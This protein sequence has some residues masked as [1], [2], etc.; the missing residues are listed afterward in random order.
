[1]RCRRR[2]RVFC[3]K[4]AGR[5]ENGVLSHAFFEGV[6]GLTRRVMRFGFACGLPLGIFDEKKPGCS[7]L[8]LTS[9]GVADSSR[10]WHAHPYYSFPT[11]H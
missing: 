2:A 3:D 11:Y 7:V 1:M 4:W 8:W 10:G 9:V 6:A 5:F